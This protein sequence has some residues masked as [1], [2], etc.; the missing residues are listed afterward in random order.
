MM[1]NPERPKGQNTIACNHWCAF[2][3]LFWAYNQI[4]STACANWQKLWPFSEPFLSDTWRIPHFSDSQPMALPSHSP[5]TVVPMPWHSHPRRAQCL[6][7]QRR[8]K[9]NR[10]TDKH[11]NKLWN[12]LYSL[13]N[14]KILH[15]I[16]LFQFKKSHIWIC[17]LEGKSASFAPLLSRVELTCL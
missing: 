17:K 15:A 2:S 1:Q 7:R 12:N 16:N 5:S 3:C 8:I 10:K 13:I 9:A 6:Q 14:F 4:E 11:T